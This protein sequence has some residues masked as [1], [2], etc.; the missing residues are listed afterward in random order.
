MEKVKRAKE[1]ADSWMK[2]LDKQP[3]EKVMTMAIYEVLTDEEQKRKDLKEKLTD[4]FDEFLSVDDIY[5]T[6]EEKKAFYQEF[7]T[8]FDE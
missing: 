4:W 2:E 1:I 6:H 7:E 5:M 8:L 3:V